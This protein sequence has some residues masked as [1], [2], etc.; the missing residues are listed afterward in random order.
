MLSA[1][2]NF[3]VTFLISALVFGVL[4]YIAT[5]IVTNTVGDI[6]DDEG[7]SLNEVI[8]NQDNALIDENSEN[9]TVEAVKEIKGE[10]FNF[11]IAVTDSRP[12]LYNDYQP[13]VSFMYNTDW[14]SVSPDKTIGCLSSDYRE[15]NITSIVLVRID[16]ENQ[17][18]LYT[19]FSPEAVVYTSTGNHSLSD[20]YN[21]YGIERLA[22]YIY[23]FTGLEIK[24]KSVING[25]DLEELSSLLGPI[26]I[27]LG[28]DI[29]S[30]GK[31]NTMQYETTI[32]HV[33]ADGSEWTEHKPNTYLLGKGTVSL[34]QDNIFNVLTAREH[35]AAD[36]T[37]K[38]EYTIEILQ[39][40]ITLLAGMEES[41]LKIILAQLITNEKDWGN[42]EGLV[43]PE[44]E[45]SAESSAEE[46]IPETEENNE[47]EN[48][49]K[50]VKWLRET[51]EPE[52]PIVNTNFTMNDFDDVYELICAVTEFENITITYPAS[53]MPAGEDYGEYF[54]LNTNAGLELFMDYRK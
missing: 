30:D 2:K 53:Y 47:E 35:S 45:E 44:T 20:V 50:E 24:Y 3:G 7:A 49:E 27:E 14:Y 15:V 29:Y 37:A 52:G 36:L 38:E 43:L 23:S 22:E 34:N 26:Q 5:G 1:F 21:L 9:T 41:Q 54:D 16:K 10:S 4:A 12:D 6:L 31:Y 39:K 42:I 28:K 17:E 8:Q 32:E 51:Y 11:L 48:Q 33:E 40:Y 46:N 19:Y 13:E 18:Y 25:Y